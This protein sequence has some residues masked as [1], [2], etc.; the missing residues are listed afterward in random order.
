M[1]YQA[2]QCLST[3]QNGFGGEACWHELCRSH[4]KI[5][6]TFGLAHRHDYEQKV[7]DEYASDNQQIQV[8]TVHIRV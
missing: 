3:L 4:K 1:L 7:K 5:Q 6:R 8:Y 2:V